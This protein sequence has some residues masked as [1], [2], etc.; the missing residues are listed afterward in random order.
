MRAGHTLLE[1]TV[2]LLLA[3]LAGTAVLPAAR[4]AADRAAVSGARE[5]LAG[6]VARARTEAMTLGGASLRTRAADATAWV[7][8]GDSVIGLR[9]LGDEF[10]VTLDVGAAE[11]ELDFDALGLGR[12]AS[13]TLIVRRGQAEARLVVA[14]YGRAVGS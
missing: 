3:G 13:R 10:G 2:V 14:A 6:L 11:A 9:G 4:R 5:A 8:A 12:R 7:Q 1:L